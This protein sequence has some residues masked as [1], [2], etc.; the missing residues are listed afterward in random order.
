[1]EKINKTYRYEEEV[2]K[3][4]EN[5]P[6]IQSFAVW[7]CKAY[8]KEFMDL[9]SKEKALLEAK[10]TVSILQKEIKQL[11]SQEKKLFLSKEEI[12]ELKGMKKRIQRTTFEGCFNSFINE[13][14]RTDINRR[15]FKLLVE[16]YG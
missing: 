16:R 14:G 4:A 1:M 7:A 2:I 13:T 6:K 9:E 8:K 15:Q 10:N 3:H 12:N 11:K 5:N